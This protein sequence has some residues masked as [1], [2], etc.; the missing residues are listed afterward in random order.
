[1]FTKCK[2]HSLRVMRKL[3]NQFTLLLRERFTFKPHHSKY[4][5]S[6]TI[7]LVLLS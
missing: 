4:P 2:Q 3:F 5:K 7:F 6:R 1:M